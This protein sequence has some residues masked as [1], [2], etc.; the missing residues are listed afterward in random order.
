MQFKVQNEANLDS[1]N[2]IMNTI[3]LQAANSLS[4]PSPF[5]VISFTNQNDANNHNINLTNEANVSV[6][7]VSPLV[8]N[9][10]NNASNNLCLNLND[11]NSRNYLWSLLKT[12]SPL[13]ELIEQFGAILHDK[14]TFWDLAQI[15]L[16][17][18][19]TNHL[20]A[21]Y[22]IIDDYTILYSNMRTYLEKFVNEQSTSN[23]NVNSSSRKVNFNF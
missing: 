7:N 13:E 5:P 18:T 1:I 22:Q 16:K 23:N 4:M 11:V 8:V 20:K 12:H 15:K 17:H 19:K 21:T 2:N 10:M 14:I 6:I 9:R 3:N